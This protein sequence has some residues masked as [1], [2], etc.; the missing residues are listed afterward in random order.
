MGTI[1]GL[2][3]LL[4]IWAMLASAY[5]VDLRVRLRRTLEVQARWWAP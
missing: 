3:V 4:L 2:D 5:C 1:N